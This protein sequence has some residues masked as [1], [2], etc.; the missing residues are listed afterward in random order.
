[1]PARLSSMEL[2]SPSNPDIDPSARPS[3]RKSGRVSKKPEFLAP[4]PAGKRKR[5]D[6]D[7]DVEDQ[8]G[9]ADM[10]DASET[11]SD[12]DDDDPDEEEL[13]EQRRKKKKKRRG[14]ADRPK[15]AAPRRKPNG[16]ASGASTTL[17][18]RPAKKAAK[19]KKGQFEAEAAEEIGG[20]YGEHVRLQRCRACTLI[21]EKAASSAARIP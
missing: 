14:N 5:N 6:G 20:L 21:V 10:D 2:S 12:D 13:R 17:V 19:A 4:G 15:P 8:D 7:V 9:D 16:V 11:A 18:R 1:M 3:R